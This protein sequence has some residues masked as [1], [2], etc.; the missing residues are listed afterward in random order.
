MLVIT[1]YLRECLLLVREIMKKKVITI[2]C[3]DSVLDACNKYRDYKIG[4]LV[5]TEKGACVGCCRT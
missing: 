3:D 1:V 5:V 4:C 2:D